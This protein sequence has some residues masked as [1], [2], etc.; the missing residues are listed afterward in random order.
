MGEVGVSANDPDMAALDVLGDILNSFGGRLFDRIRSREVRAPRL[1]HQ[2]SETMMQQGVP[3][4][5]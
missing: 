5:H 4:K 1:H 3:L 2:A